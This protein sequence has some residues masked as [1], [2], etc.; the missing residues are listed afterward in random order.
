MA[1]IYSRMAKLGLLNSGDRKDAALMGL[2]QL[3]GQ[4][5]NRGAPRLSPTPPP[6]DLGAAM[7]TYQQGMSNAMQRSLLTRKFE[8]DQA[9]RSLYSG[10]N[11]MLEGLNPGTQNFLKMIGKTHPEI[12]TTMFGNLLKERYK[13]KKPDYQKAIIGGKPGIYSSAE[14][15]A[16]KNA[17]KTVTPHV[18]PLVSV[19]QVGLYNRARNEWVK[20]GT[21][22]D[23]PQEPQD[24]NV[25]PSPNNLNAPKVIPA[26]S[27]IT[28][29]KISVAAYNAGVEEVK[30]LKKQSLVVRKI[31]QKATRFLELLE[32]Q[33]TGGV[34]R[35]IPGSGMVESAFDP[36]IQ[37]MRS[38][39]DYLTPL[40]RKGLPGA[41]S[42]KDVSM[43]RGSTV[44][45]DKL[46]EVNRVIGRGHQAAARNARGRVEFFEAYLNKNQRMSGAE[47]KWNKYLENEPIFDPKSTK[48][49]PRFNK[50]RK[51]WQEYFGLIKVPNSYN[52]EPITEADIRQTMDA[53][54]M[55][56]DD[57]LKAIGAKGVM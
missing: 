1:D 35:A 47:E 42:D 56:R 37:E 50:Y 13:V 11:K 10:P 43:F 51:S 53:N 24:S 44:G 40:M 57:V 18:D 33:Q 2:L 17:G 41:A 36:E 26:G 54:D 12:A 22:S 8:D 29:E 14:I 3:G 48:A 45:T 28:T 21:P 9:L 34:W 25:M 16:A 39:S 15:K 55:T 52:G 46:S 23:P 19:P 6:I 38:I 5:A 4:L 27:P 20:V 30:T 49:D 31:E 7:K 32:K